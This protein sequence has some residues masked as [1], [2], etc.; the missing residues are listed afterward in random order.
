MSR[1]AREAY[2]TDGFYI[3]HGLLDCALINE[4]VTSLKQAYD[5]VL[6]SKGVDAGTDIAASMKHLYDVD[7]NLYKQVTGALWRKLSIYNLLHHPA[8]AGFLHDNLGWND[9][10]I[11][12]GQVVHI[13]SEMLRIPGGYYGFSTHQ[14][15]PSVRGSL[16]GMVVWLPLVDV[17]KDL[18][19]L[20]VIPRSHRNGLLPLNQDPNN[21]WELCPDS[22][23]ASDFVPV[24]VKKGDVVFM[25]N[26]TVHRSGTHGRPDRVRLACS[27]RYDNGDE[28][29]FIERGYP[30]AYVRSVNR[31][32][33]DPAK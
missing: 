28:P 29:T 2:E 31:Y 4:T 8:I 12:G 6:R 22:Y 18:Y 5:K 32:L 10:Y 33:D 7:L 9:I 1:T 21:P 24:E 15:W 14:D 17:D 23:N 20:E 26:F 30:T 25:S 13:M 27:T 19:P 3:A 16:D 11:P